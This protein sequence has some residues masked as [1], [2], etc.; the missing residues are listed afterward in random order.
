M[1]K[2]ILLA[3]AMEQLNNILVVISWFNFLCQILLYG[4]CTETL[5]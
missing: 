3:E 1:E 4:V 5:A 2:D